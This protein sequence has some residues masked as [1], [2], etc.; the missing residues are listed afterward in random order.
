MI[1]CT[2]SLGLRFMMECTVRNKVVHASLWNTITTLV[3]GSRVWYAL[4][5]HLKNIYVEISRLRA[6]IIYIYYIWLL[7]HSNFDIDETYADNLTSARD[8]FNEIISEAIKL[9]WLILNFSFFSFSRLFGM[10]T[11]LPISP[12]EPLSP[13]TVLAGD[14]STM[15]LFELSPSFS[16]WLPIADSSTYYHKCSHVKTAN[17]QPCN[18]L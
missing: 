5:L 14:H 17:C 15:P 13:I 1:S 8:L 6:M 4:L 2:S 12:G 16:I 7:W 3:V 11:G 9:N 18:N 10:L